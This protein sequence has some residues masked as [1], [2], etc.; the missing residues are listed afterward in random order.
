[1]AEIKEVESRIRVFRWNA[2]IREPR[3]GLF[4]IRLFTAFASPIPQ[5]CTI[6]QAGAFLICKS[7]LGD[8][9]SF[10]F[11]SLMLSEI[12]GSRN[13]LDSC[14]N[15][16]SLAYDLASEIH[17]KFH[18][19]PEILSCEGPMLVCFLD[20]NATLDKYVES[21]ADCSMGKT[22]ELDKFI[23]YKGDVSA[24]QIEDLLNILFDI[25]LSDS[26]RAEAAKGLV[27]VE[28][29]LK[30]H[31][32][33]KDDERCSDKSEE[34]V[35]PICLERFSEGMEVAELPCSHTFHKGCIFR[36]LVG[37]NSCPTCRSGCAA[38]V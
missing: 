26:E 9:N 34:N 15:V 8:F 21:A 30:V 24:N 3:G 32:Y 18:F 20:L 5:P 35:C 17:G 23:E 10:N 33:N 31:V 29:I 16:K 7:A 12:L 28:A 2:N 14:T 37:T 27:E 13:I 11:K 1:M 36:W 38:C 4:L 22:D 6:G 19:S 25:D